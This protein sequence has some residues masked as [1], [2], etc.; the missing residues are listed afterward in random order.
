MAKYSSKQT[1][2]MILRY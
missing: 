1:P 2:K